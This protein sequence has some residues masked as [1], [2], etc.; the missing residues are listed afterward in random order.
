[1]IV[2]KDIFFSEMNS[3]DCLK[4]PAEEEWLMYRNCIVIS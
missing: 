3:F 1:M 4:T 2:L